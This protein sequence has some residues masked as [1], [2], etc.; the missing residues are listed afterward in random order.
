MKNFGK[1]IESLLCKYRIS[2]SLTGLFFTLFLIPVVLICTFYVI[3]LYNSM[4]AVEM[5]KVRSSLEKT[6]SEF[7]ESLTEAKS[8]SDRLYVNKKIQSILLQEYTDIQDIYS[9]Y[10]ELSFLEDYLRNYKEIAN[11]RIYVKNETLL[12]NSYIV[13]TSQET[14]EEPWFKTAVIMK[15]HP[16]WQITYDKKTKKKYLSLVRS[17]WSPSYKKYIGVLVVNMNSDEIQKNMAEQLYE[18]L[19]YFDDNYIYSSAKNISMD[20]IKSLPVI[21]KN[22]DFTDRYI[23]TQIQSEDVGLFAKDFLPYNSM[24]IKFKIVYIIPL[25]QLNVMTRNNIYI[26]LFLL[27]SMILLS[28]LVFIIYSKYI[29]KRVSKVQSGIERVV[30]NNF[31]IER[32]IGGNDEFESIYKNL[33]SMSDNLKKLVDEVYQQKIEKEHI[34]AAQSEMS[35][36]MLSSQINPHFLF[37]TIETIRMKSLAAGDK[38]VSKM[39]KLLAQLLRYNLNV[40]GKPVPLSKEIEAINNY[41]TIQHMRFGDRI[42]Y[43]INADFDMENYDIL[44]LIIQPIVENSFNHGLEDREK[45][46]TININLELQKFRYYKVM[47]I[48]VMDNGSGM[49]EEKLQQLRSDINQNKSDNDKNGDV[50]IG[51]ANVNSRIKLYYKEGSGITINST[52]GQGTEVCIKLVM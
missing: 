7:N 38:D 37:N 1:G 23:R 5:E 13:K 40:K 17:L 36:K 51:L 25:R 30:Y 32:S 10:S 11:F 14:Y 24:C 44:P 4:Q 41:L 12:D 42:E 33:Y 6:E 48:K 27:S 47:T 16:F 22:Q 20:E 35:F 34:K 2:K 8:F 28:G 3:Y 39:L 46:G 29:S 45:G 21:L 15:G 9:A 18:T 50:S 31:E 19:I 43:T 49:P 52:A 26:T